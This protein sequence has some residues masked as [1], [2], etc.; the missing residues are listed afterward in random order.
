MQ[1]LVEIVPVVLGKNIFTCRKCISAI[2]ILSPFE[3]GLNSTFEKTWVPFLQESFVPNLVVIGPMV[4]KKICQCFLRFCC[5]LPL[6][7]ARSFIWKIKRLPFPVRCVV[8][9]LVEIGPV[10]L[11]KITLTYECLPTDRQRDKRTD[12]QMDDRQQAIKQ[13]QLSLKVKP[14]KHYMKSW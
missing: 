2:S 7:I 13:A 12:R 8:S 4:L 6:K 9:S 3:K 10:V 14:L 11:R 1:S 5:Y